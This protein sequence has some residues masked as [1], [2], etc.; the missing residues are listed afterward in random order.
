MTPEAG[1]DGTVRLVSAPDSSDRVWDLTGRIEPLPGCAADVP[2]GYRL[3]LVARP[4]VSG[5]EGEALRITPS[6]VYPTWQ[7]AEEALARLAREV[8]SGLGA[9]S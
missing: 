2:A 4:R 9:G 8:G 3:S 7:K 6:T 1:R 5:E